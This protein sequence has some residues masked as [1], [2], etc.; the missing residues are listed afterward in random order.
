MLMMVVMMVEM[1]MVD[2]MMVVVRILCSW[3][4]LG[5]GFSS[6]SYFLQCHH[7][8]HRC[9][10]NHP[11]P[12]P[13]GNLGPLPANSLLNNRWPMVMTIM[14][15]GQW[16]MTHDGSRQIGTQLF[17]LSKRTAIL[18]TFRLLC[19][20]PRLPN[21]PRTKADNW[22]WWLE[23]PHKIQVALDDLTSAQE[24]ANRAHEAAAAALSNVN[25]VHGGYDDHDGHDDDDDD[26]D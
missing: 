16:S 18:I 10:R 26:D 17:T 4:W 14:S 25:Q 9:H 15:H 20:L 3:W 1:M 13:P 8:R 24:A 23:H 2:M 12:F 6:Y 7:R 19:C 5:Y 22:F 11:P 21:L